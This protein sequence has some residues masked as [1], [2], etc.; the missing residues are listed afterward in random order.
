MT[1]LIIGYGN[2]LCGDDGIGVIAAEQLDELLTG[3]EF[4]VQVIIAHQLLPEMVIDIAAAEFVLF[5]DAAV[6]DIPGEI[7]VAPVEPEP[8][9]VYVG[10]TFTPH[11][12]IG[13]AQTVGGSAPRAVLVTI[14][15]GV[16]D[17]GAPLSA[18]VSEVLDRVVRLCMDQ[19]EM[20]AISG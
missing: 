13:L 6:G 20:G 18:P 15:G 19:V 16:F 3:A 4:P 1:T 9:G 7:R 5:I 11:T 2:P 12:L 8:P 10:H 17:L 14:T